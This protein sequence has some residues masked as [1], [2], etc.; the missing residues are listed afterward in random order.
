MR[1]AHTAF[2]A[3]CGPRRERNQTR[4]RRAAGSGSISQAQASTV[5]LKPPT[6]NVGRT[7]LA[8]AS[9]VFA[10]A[11]CVLIAISIYH[12]RLG[13]GGSRG[14]VWTRPRIEYAGVSLAGRAGR[15]RSDA[16]LQ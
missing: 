12:L 13:L 14:G 7:S 15:P 1:R 2:T 16:A 8:G 10:E 6:C 3:S 5:A 4:I 9:A 11:S